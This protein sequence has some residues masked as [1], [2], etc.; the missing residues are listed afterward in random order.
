MAAQSSVSERYIPRP[1]SF[2]HCSAA[3]SGTSVATGASVAAGAS[4]ATGASLAAGAS[5]LAGAS[6]AAGAAVD[7]LQDTRKLI[8]STSEAILKSFFIY[9][10]LFC[11][12]NGRKS[13]RIFYLFLSILPPYNKFQLTI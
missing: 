9:Y 2:A 7:G 6:G 3:L 13:L 4:V 1:L 8:T 5:V 11:E 10:S 12:Q